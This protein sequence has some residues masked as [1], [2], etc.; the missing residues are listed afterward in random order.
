MAYPDQGRPGRSNS[1]SSTANAMTT[2]YAARPRK[3]TAHACGACRLR[4]S[5]C[6]GR[7]PCSWCTENE[8]DCL[9]GKQE[10]SITQGKSDQILETVLRMD[11]LLRSIH[12]NLNEH[13]HVRSIASPRFSDPSSPDHQDFAKV[14]NATISSTHISATQDL[15]SGSFAAPFP[16]LRAQFHPIFLLESKCPPMPVQP[17]SI[18]P[19]FTTDEAERLLT[20]FQRNVNFWYPTVSKATLQVLFEKVR[21]G[22]MGNT[23]EDCAA[24]LVMALGAASELIHVVFSQT[25]SRGF[26]SRQQQSELMTIANVCFD[27][28]LKL[29]TVA[30]MDV[31]TIATQ[32]VFLAALYC[33]FL[34]RPLQT[35]GHLNTAAAKCRSLIAYGTESGNVED[36]ECIRR[37]F[38]SCY[39]IESDL[40]S[41]L[42]HLPQ[43]GV[44]DQ[45]S[46]VPLPGPLQTHFTE[47]ETESSAL[48]FLSC[49]SIRRLLNRVHQLLYAA[50]KH[51]TYTSSR[52]ESLRALI[53]ELDRQLVLWHDTLPGFL[54]F[55]EDTRECANEHAAFLR[56][57][58]LACKSVIYRPYVEIVLKHNDMAHSRE[59]VEG[60]GRCLKASCDH[61]AN[62]KSFGQ[63]VMIDTWICS[64]SMTSTMFII[65]VS[66]Q[67][68]ALGPTLLE[69]NI[70]DFGPHLRRLLTSWI[71]MM[72][73]KSPSIEQ[74]IRLIAEIEHLIGASR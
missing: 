14:A 9:Y 66:L 46:E 68:Q 62:L 63:T 45:E 53:T 60:A 23:C 16:S 30:Y 17:R 12:E 7:Q 54:V 13:N 3:R 39:I 69:H 49:I 71:G 5:R 38:W 32:C 34:Q 6:D 57:R 72:Q 61:I 48:Y 26:Q 18:R 4:K 28:A 74:S 33:S 52:D 11:G 35:W 2:P 8:V 20:S 31:S 22:F 50:E 51:N 37:I 25:E 21:N 42:S 15:L 70:P 10:P 67:N 40:I 19:V 36:D 43:S 24:L 58:Y 41:E 1:D 64:L 47:S 59:T 27:E 73:Q 44:A 65:L 56:Q 55:K 29:L